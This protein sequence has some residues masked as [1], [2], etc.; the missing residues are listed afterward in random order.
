MDQIF[1]EINQLFNN[2]LT[3]T[4]HIIPNLLLAIGVLVIGFVFSKISQRLIKRF[5]LYLHSTINKNL[6]SRSLSVKFTGC[7]NLLFQ[8]LIIFIFSIVVATQM[9]MTI[10]TKWFDGLIL[11]LPNILA[12]IIIVFV[13]FI[14]GELVS[15]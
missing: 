6:G 2:L 14:V 8:R 1:E 9:G 5:I 15:N 7:C 3:S 12:S 13:G 11:Y 10:L 4:I